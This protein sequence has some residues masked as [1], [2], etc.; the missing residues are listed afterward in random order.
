MDCIKLWKLCGLSG[1]DRNVKSISIVPEDSIISILDLLSEGFKYNDH[2]VI[3]ANSLLATPKYVLRL[4]KLS[5]FGISSKYH[6]NG[7]K[8]LIYSLKYLCNKIGPK[9]ISDLF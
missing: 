2:I 3:P 7:K 6:K 5:K 4:N 1:D 9:P 8:I